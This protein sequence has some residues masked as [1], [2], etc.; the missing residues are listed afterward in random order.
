MEDLLELAGNILV[1]C[2]LVVFYLTLTLVGSVVI[3]SLWQA[4]VR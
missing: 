4:V 2:F 3:K 1:W